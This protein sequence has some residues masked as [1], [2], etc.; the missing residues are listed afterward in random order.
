MG[1]NKPN[2]EATLTELET[3]VRTLE[4]GDITLNE[5]LE[6]FERGVKLTRICQQALRAAEQKVDILLKDDTPE[7][8]PNKE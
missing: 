4:Q 7:P 1:E 5:S 3:I 8:F 2:F 6:Q